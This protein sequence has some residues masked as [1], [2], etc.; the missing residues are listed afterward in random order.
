MESSLAENIEDNQSIQYSFF[1]GAGIGNEVVSAT[2]KV[3]ARIV[4]RHHHNKAGL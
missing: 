3:P 4:D 2:S 1:F